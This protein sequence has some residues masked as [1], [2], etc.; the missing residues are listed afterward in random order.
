M[1]KEVPVV[2]S[3]A[4]Y[5]EEFMEMDYFPVAEECHGGKVVYI[6]LDRTMRQCLLANTMV[7]ANHHYTRALIQIL[8]WVRC[9]WRIVLYC[10]FFCDKGIYIPISI[11]FMVRDLGRAPV[12]YPRV[13][14]IKY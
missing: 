6:L 9:R 10:Y 2:D 3:E 1:E 12:A 11:F 8:R 4:G 7:G 14:G 5:L 13:K